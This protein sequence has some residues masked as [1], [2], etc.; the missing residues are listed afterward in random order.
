[1]TPTIRVRTRTYTVHAETTRAGNTCYDL[2]NTRGQHTARL[3]NLTGIGWTL[4]G[5]PRVWT[6]GQCR[7]AAHDAR[8]AL[9]L[10]Y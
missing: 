5:A 6:N 7:E 2:T 9:G 3:A 1:M 10:A 4:I 8:T